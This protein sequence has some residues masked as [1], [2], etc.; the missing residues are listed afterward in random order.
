[1]IR[2]TILGVAAA[3]LLCGVLP[4]FGGEIHRAIEAGDIALVQKILQQ[5]PSA[6]TQPDENEFADLPIHVA[7]ATGNIEIAKLLLKAGADIDAGDSDESTA[8]GVAALR[9]QGEMLAFLIEQ[10]ADVNRRDR[11]ADYPLSFAVSSGNAAIV[12]QLVDAGADLYYR[13]PHGE[14][15]LHTASRSGLT[16]FVKHLLDNT[17]DLEAKTANG[18]TPLGYAAMGGHSEIV[19]LLLDHGANPMPAAQG[20]AGPLTF[21]AWRDQVEIARMMLDSGAAVDHL[22]HRGYTALIYAADGGSTEMV[23]LLI[24][25]GASVDIQNEDGETALVKAAASGCTGCIE[26]LMAAEAD[27]NL[28]KD[29]SGR[30][31]LQLASLGGYAEATR[32]LLAGGA[33]LRATTPAGESPYQLARYY[34]H[35]DVAAVLAKAGAST[36]SE[37]IDRSLTAIGDVGKKEAVIWFLGHSGWAVK[38]RNHLLIFDYYAHGEDPASPALCNGRINPVEIADVKVDVFASHHHGDHFDATIFEWQ[39]QVA[40]ITYYLGLRPEN[41]P[42]Y[43]YMP[44]RM[45]KKFGDLKLTTIHST[46]AGVGEVVEVDGLTIFHAGDH[47][48]GRIGLMDEFTDEIDFLAEKGIKPDVCFMGIRGCSLGRPDEVKEGIDYTLKKLQPKVFI[49]MHA[50][51][52]GHLYREYITEC[53]KKFP[54]IQMVAPDNRGDHFVYSKGKI[55]DPK[56]LGTQ[57]ASVAP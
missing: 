11:K 43:E 17:S 57:Q 1:M 41:A 10:G 9:Q 16:E 20:E 36:T 29:G 38:T 25:R 5:D 22:G 54:D 3:V 40:D 28:G 32:L 7:A 56:G 21:C 49:P 53:Q 34:G 12:Q 48:N 2:R 39:P 33:D 35:A 47:A 44:E 37:N 27:P 46:D 23:S 19:Q 6:V 8:L 55:T 42:P 14:T 18:G 26:A 4:A 31:A 30:T 51:A 13:N 52:Q 24:E 50:Q 45:E 15:L